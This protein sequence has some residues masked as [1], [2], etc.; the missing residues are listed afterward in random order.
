MC[1]LIMEINSRE[2]EMA[3]ERKQMSKKTW[4]VMI[5]LMFVVIA[6]LII[7]LVGMLA[8]NGNSPRSASQDVKPDIVAVLN[9]NLGLYS[10]EIEYQVGDIYMLD[11]GYAV[12]ILNVDEVNYRALLNNANGNWEVLSYPRVVFSYEDFPEASEGIIKKANEVG[13]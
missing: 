10:P 2:S 8:G 9:E 11:S 3:S 5:G 12:A 1:L 6:M 4:N 13:R 7:G